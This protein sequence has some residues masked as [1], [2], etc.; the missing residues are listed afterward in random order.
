MICCVAPVCFKQDSSRR[1][2]SYSTSHPASSLLFCWSHKSV[3]SYISWI[4]V[5]R[6]LWWWCVNTLMA[7]DLF[8]GSLHQP[9]RLWVCSGLVEHSN[10]MT[11]TATV[12]H[13]RITSLIVGFSVTAIVCVFSESLV[14]SICKFRCA[15]NYGM[16]LNVCSISINVSSNYIVYDSTTTAIKAVWLLSDFIERF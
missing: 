3:S 16:V 10:F 15:I 8:C 6:L 4:T 9:D 12:D 1:V 7:D 13:T 5:Y 11:A 2:G 14:A